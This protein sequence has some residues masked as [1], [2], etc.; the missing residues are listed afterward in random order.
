MKTSLYQKKKLASNPEL[1]YVKELDKFLGSKEIGFLSSSHP[2]MVT[3]VSPFVD[4]YLEYKR[5][6]TR[7]VKSKA[8]L[9]CVMF[10][11]SI[12]LPK[13]IYEPGKMKR[14]T[15]LALQNEISY[16]PCPNCMNEILKKKEK[17]K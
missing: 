9:C 2:L 7:L 8:P 5:D 4:N 13:M 6:F 11:F 10:Y 12:Y 15:T 14:Y 16:I 3:A 1:V 17:K